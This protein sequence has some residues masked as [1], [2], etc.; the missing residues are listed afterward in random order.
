[1]SYDEQHHISR[2]IKLPNFTDESPTTWLKLAEAHLTANNV[3]DVQLKI[4]SIISAL[5]PDFREETLQYLEP[6]VANAY[7]EL[8]QAIKNYNRPSE[9]NRIRQLMNAAPIGDRKPTQ[10]L[11]H[12]RSLV[13]KPED[14]LQ[15]LRRHLEDRI[16][17][18]IAQTLLACKL[19]N[20]DDYARRA[21]DL[22][23]RF[24]KTPQHQ[25]N[26]ASLSRASNQSI[27]EILPDPKSNFSSAQS[28]VVDNTMKPLSTSTYRRPT[29]TNEIAKLN[30]QINAMNVERQE[31]KLFQRQTF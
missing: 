21:D 15:I 23:D 3:A 14:Y 7:N 18:N 5:P 17:Q 22:Y 10:Y 20:I 26:Q 2:V 6:G 28:S 19:E 11:R 25:I 12:L 30:D 1:M 13:E 27:S 31:S 9:I 8:T 16:D 24:I 29:Q 4:L